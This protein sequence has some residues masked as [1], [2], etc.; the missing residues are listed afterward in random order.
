MHIKYKIN[1]IESGTVIDHLLPNKA[2]DIIEALDI[3]ERYP[4]SVVTM[5]TN[6]K[7][8]RY[9]VKDLLKI[10]GQEMS[11]KEINKIKKIAGR[12]T[13]NIIK[14]YEIIRKICAD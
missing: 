7:S 5:A 11:E 2:Y 1:K 4:N 14:D 3:K 13:I 9:G 12:M 8:G 10:E 6:V